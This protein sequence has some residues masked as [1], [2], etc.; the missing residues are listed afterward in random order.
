MA[1]YENNVF[2]ALASQDTTNII[3]LSQNSTIH[4]FTN[5]FIDFDAG[6]SVCILFENEVVNIDYSGTLIA[7][8]FIPLVN[9][10]SIEYNEFITIAGNINSNILDYVLN[11][12]QGSIIIQYNSFLQIQNYRGLAL[13]SDVSSMFS[14]SSDYFL[15]FSH[16]LALIENPFSQTFCKNCLNQTFNFFN[17]AFCSVCENNYQ[18]IG[19]HCIKTFECPKGTVKDI[20]SL[21]CMNCFVG[22]S[23]CTGINPDQCLSCSFNY[24]FYD[25]QCL[26]NCPKGMFSNDFVCLDCP[27]NCSSCTANSCLS[28]NNGLLQKGACVD[29]C[30][31]NY[32]EIENKCEACDDSCL[33]CN[34][35]GCTNCYSGYFLNSYSCDKCKNNCSVCSKND[36]LV[37]E[38]GFQLEF[39]TCYI[40]KSECLN[41]S[42]GVCSHC[43]AGFY[44]DKYNDCISC[45]EGCDDCNQTFCFK[46]SYGW[47]FEGTCIEC[48]GFMANNT[49]NYCTDGCSKCNQN[50]CKICENGFFMNENN[51]NKCSDNCEKCDSFGCFNCTKGVLEKGVC[52]NDCSLG[53]YELHGN[54]VECPQNCSSCTKGICE[55]CSF[56]YEENAVFVL[57]NGS[58]NTK[59]CMDGFSYKNGV[60]EYNFS[61]YF[62]YLQAIIQFSINFEI[63][64]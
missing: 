12:F 42:K 50:G 40:C 35:S 29:A 14:V 4:S 6:I 51:C 7:S 8:T 36:C 59:V 55:S 63:M 28:C 11:T 56:D 1:G 60:C 5:T 32:F 38:N 46:C 17:E 31:L 33:S 64:I 57:I 18:L 53:Y 10:K 61:E 47:V 49:C 45:P 3:S 21:T 20:Y 26:L 39:G 15:T 62:G 25:G 58:C 52:V 22:C 34:K 37:C 16:F 9:L 2:L 43:R 24:T 30:D 19:N 23:D 41:C 44:L 27:V 48:P 54:C 13:S